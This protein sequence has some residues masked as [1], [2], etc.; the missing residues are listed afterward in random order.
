[1]EKKIETYS[2]G[3]HKNYR[4][5]ISAEPAG[6]RDA[7]ILPQG[8]LQTSIKITNE[9]PTGMQANL[10]KALDNFTQVKT[11][12]LNKQHSSFLINKVHNSINEPH[13][14]LIV[15]NLETR[16]EV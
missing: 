5:F 8:I 3:S 15:F 11:N 7:H 10:H 1:M 14:V 2:V 13:F 9:P 12:S 6:T 4:V 16:L